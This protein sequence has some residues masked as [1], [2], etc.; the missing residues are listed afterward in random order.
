MALAYPEGLPLAMRDG[1]AFSPVNNILRTD[2]QSGRARQRIEFEN[3]PDMLRLRWTLTELQSRLF[4][5]WA[6]NVV[7]AGWFPMTILTP[8]G[9]ETLELRFTERVNGPALTGKFHWVWTATCELR[10]M[11]ELDPDWVNLPDFALQPNLLDI[12]MNRI[13]PEA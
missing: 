7:G 11:P 10:E 3:V 12:C 2:M 9:F 4:S 1:Y 6:R 5:T 13:W 8:M